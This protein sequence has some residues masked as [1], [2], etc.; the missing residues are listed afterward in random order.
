MKKFDS[1]L[2]DFDGT[3]AVINIDFPMMRRSILDTIV[4]YGVDPDGLGNLFALEMM[5]AGREIIAREKP[6]LEKEYLERTE[7]LIREIEL[8]GAK[9][10]QLFSGVREMLGQMKS[11]GIKTGVVTRNCLDAV[12]G[13]FPD[14]QQFC[15]IVV[16]R[17]TAGKSKPHPDH[18]YAA[19]KCL[20]TLP[21][22]AAIVG[23]HPMDIQAGKTAGTFTIGVLTGYG[24]RE[25]LQQAGADLIFQSAPELVR[26]LPQIP[27]RNTAST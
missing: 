22:E 23:D 2:F 19:L 16:T 24:S 8:E 17:E 21:C 27:L 14:I 20:G 13:L 3:L 9:T 4:S 7:N 18:L 15:D 25:T 10:G 5:E 1:I 26:Y 12:T 6:P 11:C